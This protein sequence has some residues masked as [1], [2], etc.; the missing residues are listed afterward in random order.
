[1][2]V[3]CAEFLSKRG[4]TGCTSIAS[5]LPPI[6]EKLVPPPRDTDT[7]ART[8]SRRGAAMRVTSTMGDEPRREWSFRA[9]LLLSICALV[10]LT[11]AAI[12]L[13]A[14]RSFR[15]SATELAT[16]LF[17]E[18]SGHAVTRARGFVSGAVPIVSSL[19]ELAG[20]GL[21][22]ED[23]DRLA[24]QLTGVLRANPALTWV[25]Y[26][27]ERGTFTGAYRTQDGVL[28]VNQSHI[29]ASTGRTK[30]VAQNVLPSGV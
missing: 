11:G 28:R 12:T 8:I 10:L 25:S 17:R 3:A 6:R 29:D 18:V 22:I 26:G 2:P 13:L 1:M 30:L 7:A 16:G 15:A 9:K 19:K 24:R 21:A 14:V 20:D 5:L 27:D 4:G 23:S